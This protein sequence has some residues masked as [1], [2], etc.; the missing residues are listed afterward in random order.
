MDCD[1]ITQNE[2]SNPECDQGRWLQDHVVARLQQIDGVKLASP[3]GAFYVMPDVSALIGDGV[4]VEGFGDIPDV[5]TLC[6]SA[7][8]PLQPIQCLQVRR[9]PAAAAA[10]KHQP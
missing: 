10:A 1:N 7:R 8:T 2:P 5:D 9:T 6:R 3:Q 4:E